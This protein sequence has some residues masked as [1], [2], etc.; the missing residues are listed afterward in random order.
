MKFN[1][2]IPF[3]TQDVYAKEIGVFKLFRINDRPTG[4]AICTKF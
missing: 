4:S 3:R 2:N 1:D